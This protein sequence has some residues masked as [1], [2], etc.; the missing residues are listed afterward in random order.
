MKIKS[1]E[2]CIDTDSA[3]HRKLSTIEESAAEDNDGT[4][5]QG[6]R[7][8]ILSK[9]VDDRQNKKQK[10]TPLIGISAIATYTQSIKEPPVQCPACNKELINNYPLHDHM[11][12]KSDRQCNDCKLFF[13]SCY[14]LGR[15]QNGRC[16]KRLIK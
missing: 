3:I 15:H 14:V 4:L 1:M 12:I 11:Q 2:E 6:K 7:K 10:K 8:L 16:R 5:S 13:A 9:K